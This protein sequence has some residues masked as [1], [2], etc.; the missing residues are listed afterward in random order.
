M[1]TSTSTEVVVHY[2]AYCHR[3]SVVCVSVC[4]CLLVTTANCAKMDEPTEMPFAMWIGV[5]P[6]NHML[7]ASL[8][9]RGSFGGI[10]RHTVKYGE[11]PNSCL[12]GRAV[13]PFSVSLQCQ[14]SCSIFVFLSPFFKSWLCTICV[15]SHIVYT[16]IYFSWRG[17]LLWTRVWLMDD[18]TLVHR[19]RPHQ[20]FIS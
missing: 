16:C 3:R 6:T 8:G 17:H 14:L 20:L 2:A 10:S 11:Y 19:R 13:R 5:G 12:S 15:S 4:V 7:G 9:E 18:Q 1:S